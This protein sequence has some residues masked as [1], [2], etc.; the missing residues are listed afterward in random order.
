MKKYMEIEDSSNKKTQAEYIKSQQLI[1]E[2]KRRAVEL[3]KKNKIKNELER[4]IQ[5]EEERNP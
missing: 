3:E 2:E 5:E 4:K 1:A